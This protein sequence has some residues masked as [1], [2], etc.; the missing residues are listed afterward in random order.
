MKANSAA[1]SVETTLDSIKSVLFPII[2][3]GIF[4]LRFSFILGIKYSF[5][6]EKLF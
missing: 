5:I 3:I 6:S 1:S 2:N 4:S